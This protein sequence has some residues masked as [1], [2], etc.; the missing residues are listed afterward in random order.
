M[1]E[2][3]YSS[4]LPTALASLVM[5]ALCQTFPQLPPSI[6]LSI[7]LSIHLSILAFEPSDL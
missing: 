1:N 7:C 6:C 3:Q 2:L 5:T 4:K